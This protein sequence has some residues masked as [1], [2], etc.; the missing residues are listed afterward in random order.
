MTHLR[1]S[2]MP[3]SDLPPALGLIVLQADETLEPDFRNIFADTNVALYVSRIPSAPDVTPETLRAMEA[4]IAVSANLLPKSLRYDVVGYGCTS[5]SAIIGSDAVAD[6]VRTS[7]KTTEVTNPLHAAIAFAHHHGLER[8]AVLSPYVASVNAPLRTAFANAGIT[9]DTFGSFGEPEEAKVARIAEE[10]IVDA[11]T[12]L[13]DGADIDGV[14]LSCTNLKTLQAIP[15]I[16]KATNKPV[17][18]S[19]SALAWHMKKLSRL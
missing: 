18:S 17:F 4:D 19:N 8:L 14:F 16:C 1:Y 9:T 5:A 7:C 3:D 15:R 11:A 2:L 6:L 12:T 13:A 10:S